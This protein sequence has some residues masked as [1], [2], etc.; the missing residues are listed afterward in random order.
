MVKV[1]INECWLGNI[2]DNL[3]AISA[4]PSFA[5]KYKNKE[6]AQK[7]IDAFNSQSNVDTKWKVE[8]VED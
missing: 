7:A 2:R 3:L 6:E 8:I 5:T 1:K 4:E